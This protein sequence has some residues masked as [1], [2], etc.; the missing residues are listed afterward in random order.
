MILRD[1]AN[2]KDPVGAPHLP[3]TTISH[4]WKSV[5]SESLVLADQPPLTSVVAIGNT[6]TGVN[7]SDWMMTVVIERN[8]PVIQ[9]A[10]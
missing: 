8:L 4:Q 1:E 10:V 7:L 3:V 9:S 6:S 5:Q 2:E